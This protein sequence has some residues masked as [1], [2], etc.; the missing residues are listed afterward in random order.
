M[1]QRLPVLVSVLTMST[2]D[3]PA[4]GWPLRSI[5]L[6][7]TRTVSGCTYSENGVET[8]APPVARMRPETSPYCAAARVAA[9]LIRSG[10]VAV[11]PGAIV[12]AFRPSVAIFDFT[13]EPS[14][15]VTPATSSC[16]V[17]G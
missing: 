17:T 13:R 9:G 15:P 3:A 8:V 4:A 14:L 7:V 12:I 6:M 1:Y 16:R 10:T 5:I 2:E 11:A